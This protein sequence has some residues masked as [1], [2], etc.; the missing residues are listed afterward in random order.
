M[1]Q[2]LQEGGLAS[3][4]VPHN[5]QHWLARSAPASPLHLSCPLYLQTMARVGSLELKANTAVLLQQ[6]CG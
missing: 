4:G 5:S 3:I 1:S 6:P 2:G